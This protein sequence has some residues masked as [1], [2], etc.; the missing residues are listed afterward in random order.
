MS[1][2]IIA[3]CSLPSDHGPQYLVFDYSSE[4]L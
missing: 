3:I 4:H 1:S 2:A